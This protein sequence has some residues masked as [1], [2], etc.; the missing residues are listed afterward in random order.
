MGTFAEAPVPAAKPRR[1]VCAAGYIWLLEGW[2]PPKSGSP[3]GAK[4]GHG[5]AITV[6]PKIYRRSAPP[7]KFSGAGKCRFRAGQARTSQTVIAC[8]LQRRV[9]V[10]CHPLASVEW[11][12]TVGNVSRESDGTAA[13]CNKP[14]QITVV[15]PPPMR[16]ALTIEARTRHSARIAQVS[17]ATP[18]LIA[19]RGAMPGAGWK[20]RG[21]GQGLREQVQPPSFVRRADRTSG[22]GPKIKSSPKIDQPRTVSKAAPGFLGSGT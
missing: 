14:L 5:A 11:L 1:S 16:L 4:G 17:A 15:F 22:M 8:D 9:V 10:A 6:R 19:G 7:P 12:T 20:P 3:P 21:S 2:A 13:F 18:A